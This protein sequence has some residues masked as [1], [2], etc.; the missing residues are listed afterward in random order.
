MDGGAG[1]GGWG[2]GSIWEKIHKKLP[3]KSP[4]LLTLLGLNPWVL[5]ISS[6]KKFHFIFFKENFS[7]NQLLKSDFKRCL[8]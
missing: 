5:Q 1:V 7:L 6:M 8:G 3:S 4:A 2:W